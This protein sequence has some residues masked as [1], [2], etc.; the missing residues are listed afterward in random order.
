MPMVF[1]IKNSYLKGNKK[2]KILSQ[3]VFTLI[4]DGAII[5]LLIW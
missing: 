1:Y 3:K 5:C 2:L 4:L